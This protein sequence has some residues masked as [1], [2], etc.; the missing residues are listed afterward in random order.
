MIQDINKLKLEERVTVLNN[1]AVETYEEGKD[2]KLSFLIPALAK[3]DSMILDCNQFDEIDSDGNAVLVERVIRIKRFVRKE[4]L[5]KKG[6]DY[7]SAAGLYIVVPVYLLPAKKIRRA[8]NKKRGG[9]IP[10]PEEYGLPSTEEVDYATLKPLSGTCYTAL[11][12]MSDDYINSLVS[13]AKNYDNVG[14]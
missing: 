11:A 14:F 4:Y 10:N 3:L 6:I 2:D 12:K 7:V 8:M 5:D 1:L 13:T 9:W